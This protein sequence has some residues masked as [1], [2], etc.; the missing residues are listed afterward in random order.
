MASKY[1]V[2]RPIFNDRF[3]LVAAMPSTI[4]CG[5]CPSK[6]ITSPPAVKASRAALQALV[7]YRD[8]TRA[9]LRDSAWHA[10]GRWAVE[11]HQ[12]RLSS[13]G[14]PS[15]TVLPRADGRSLR[16]ASCQPRSHFFAV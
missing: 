3:S 7:W 9:L 14:C 6:S 15:M 1:K 13:D 2:V 8:R 11:S 10:R 16:A 4:H 5:A 12:I